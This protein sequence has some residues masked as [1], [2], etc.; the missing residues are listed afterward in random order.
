[1]NTRNVTIIQ[2]MKGYIIIGLMR[3][4]GGGGGGGGTLCQPTKESPGRCLLV[5]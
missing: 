4:H 5:R 1:M 3:P 2:V